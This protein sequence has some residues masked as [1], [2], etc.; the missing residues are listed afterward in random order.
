MLQSQG[1]LFHRLRSQISHSAKIWRAS[2]TQPGGTQCIGTTTIGILHHHRAV[3][4]EL[5]LDLSVG[6]ITHSHGFTQR[7][8]WF[9]VILIAIII[10]ILGLVS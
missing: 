7:I 8:Y 1:E 2:S 3:P 9:P 10:G 5:E 4:G 6:S